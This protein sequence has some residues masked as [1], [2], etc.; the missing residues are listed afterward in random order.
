MTQKG[1]AKIILVIVVFVLAVVVGYF[2]IF[3]KGSGPVVSTKI[4]TLI[5]PENGAIYGR[6][7]DI[8][9]TGKTKPSYYVQVYANYSAKD[10]ECLTS[11]SFSNGG[12]G[13]A[14]TNGEFDFPIA[15]QGYRSGQNNLVVAV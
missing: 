6:G 13:R 7:E 4:V 1:V 9:I 14:D 3:R 10:L 11:S 12:A 2:T 15:Y 8:R 5:S